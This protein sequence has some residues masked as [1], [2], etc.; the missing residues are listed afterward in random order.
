MKDLLE[1]LNVESTESEMLLE[2]SDEAEEAEA[3]PKEADAE[4]KEVYDVEE[5]K[6]LFISAQALRLITHNRLIAIIKNFTKKFC[7]LCMG[8]VFL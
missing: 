3:E 5:A 1:L 8:N 7:I 2:L 4:P 6:K